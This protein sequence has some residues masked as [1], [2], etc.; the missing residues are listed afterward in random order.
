MKTFLTLVLVLIVN[1]VYSADLTTNKNVTYKDYEIL[2][3]TDS[4]VSISHEAGACKI[5]L[6]ELPA[7]VKSQLKSQ[8]DA[9]KNERLKSPTKEIYTQEIKIVKPFKDPEPIITDPKIKEIMEDI[10]EKE[11]EI[12][13]LKA[14]LKQIDMD[15][16]LKDSFKNSANSK[17]VEAL[18]DKKTEVL[19]SIRYTQNNIAQKQQRLQRL[20]KTK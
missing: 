20:L 18:K 9:Y 16:R 1:A 5:P 13:D 10:K 4:Y 12:K 14:Q 7:D 8:I 17:K 2:N 19:E 15:L 6:G 11:K 3:V